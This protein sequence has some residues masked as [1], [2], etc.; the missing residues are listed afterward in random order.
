[1]TGLHIKVELQIIHLQNVDCM[2][3]GNI[4]DEVNCWIVLHMCI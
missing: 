1:M 3:N 4:V 2:T